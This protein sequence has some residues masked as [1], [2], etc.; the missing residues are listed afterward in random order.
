[1]LVISFALFVHSVN[2]ITTLLGD[3]VLSFVHEYVMMRWYF[4]NGYGKTLL[5]FSY[6]V[7]LLYL[8]IVY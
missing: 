8:S 6:G 3:A 5:D 1:M 4:K 7:V 2:P